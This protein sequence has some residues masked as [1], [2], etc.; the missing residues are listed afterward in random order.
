[1]CAEGGCL[2]KIYIYTSTFIHGVRFQ[3]SFHPTLLHI[4]D[5][6]I[7]NRIMRILNIL[8]KKKKKPQ[9]SG[10]HAFSRYY[11]YHHYYTITI[12]IILYYY[13]PHVVVGI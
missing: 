1:M 12:G 8:F 5:I 7:S 9:L 4:V 6:D 3:A 13:K 2:N 11:Y 10:R